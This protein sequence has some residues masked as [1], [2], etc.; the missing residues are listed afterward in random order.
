MSR[1]TTLYE[2]LKDKWFAIERR[3]GRGFERIHTRGVNELRRLAFIERASDPL[4]WHASPAGRAWLAA[5]GIV[6]DLDKLSKS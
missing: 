5:K 2:C 3:P 1:G 6:A 4:T